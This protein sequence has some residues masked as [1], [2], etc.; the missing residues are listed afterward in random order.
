MRLRHRSADA[1]LVVTCGSTEADGAMMTRA[2][3]RDIGCRVSPF[4]ETT[5]PTTDLV[6]G[7]PIYVSLNPP[8]F[9]FDEA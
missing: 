9:R 4:Y 5:W 2:I 8:E 1:N 6:G 7:E 3:P